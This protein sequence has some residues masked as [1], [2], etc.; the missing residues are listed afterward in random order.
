MNSFRFRT[1][2]AII[3]LILGEIVGAAFF[4]IARVQE[5]T[6]GAFIATIPVPPALLFFVGVPVGALAALWAAYK[7]S[8]KLPFLPQI[9]KFVA[10]G[11]SNTAIDWG[12][13]NLLLAPLGLGTTTFAL[14]KG[15]SFAVATLN[16]FFWNKYWT[17]EKKQTAGAGREAALFYLFTAVGLGINVGAATLFKVLG[18]DTKFWAGILAPGFATLI[19]AVW[20]FLSYKLVVF[21]K[22]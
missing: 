8:G 4:A 16:S 19:S 7:V 13:L 14:A 18:P 9:A 12:L 11:V 6:I 2:D 20:N 5:E 1:I 10:V 22:M 21:R 15:F 3:I 17:F